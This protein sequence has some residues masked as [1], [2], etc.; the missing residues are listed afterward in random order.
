MVDWKNNKLEVALKPTE[1]PQ[2][3]LF[4]QEKKKVLFVSLS[5]IKVG[6]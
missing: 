2:F 6:Y 4:P 1:Q 5:E 3:L